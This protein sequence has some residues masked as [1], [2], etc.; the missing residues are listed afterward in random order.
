MKFAAAGLCLWVLGCASEP[1]TVERG[2]LVAASDLDN[3]PFAWMEGGRARG[4][5]VEMMERV[6][7]LVDLELDWER[8]PFPELLPA[9]EDGR[10]DCV[11]ATLG[12]T[13]ERA[14]RVA[15]SAPYFETTIVVLARA[16]AGEPQQLDELAGRVVAAGAGTTSEA[17]LRERLPHAIPFEAEKDDATTAERLLARAIDAAVL[18][19]PAARRIAAESEGRLVVLEP[20]LAVERYAIAIDPSRPELK[21]AIDVA[22][23]ELRRNGALDELDAR[24]GLTQDR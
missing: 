19:A 9:V 13:G 10:V 15:F 23:D 20:P 7:E 22:L 21:A 2:R 11:C 1:P 16:G 24:Y 12:I 3:A 5:D 18:D 4:R 6:A 14:E 8:L 17:A